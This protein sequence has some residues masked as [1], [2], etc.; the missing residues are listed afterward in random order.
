MI[1][2]RLCIAIATLVFLVITTYV[3][4]IMGQETV[5][6]SCIA[7]VMTLLSTYLWAE[8]KRPTKK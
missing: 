5:A 6:T 8:T 2:K 4:M 7:G 3:G 1:S